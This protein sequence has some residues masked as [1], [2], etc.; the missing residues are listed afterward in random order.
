[1]H[2]DLQIDI[3]TGVIPKQHV[4]GSIVQIIAKKNVF[5]YKFPSKNDVLQNLPDVIFW[6]L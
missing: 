5:M 2:N 6:L 4:T 1:M 3:D